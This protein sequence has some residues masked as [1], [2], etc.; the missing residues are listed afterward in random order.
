MQDS[1]DNVFNGIPAGVEEASRF[2]KFVDDNDFSPGTRRA[3]WFDLRKFSLWF[4][5]SNHEHFSLSRITVRDITD[6][7]EHLRRDRQQAVATVNRSLVLLR[8]YLQ[9]ATDQGLISANPAKPVKEIRQ[10][11]L[12]PKGLDRPQV[13]T[14]L[15]EVELRGDLRAAAIFHLLLYTG[16]RVSD[17]CNLELSDVQIGERVG[18]VTFR[19]GKGNK[20]RSVPL[21]MTARRALQMYLDVRPPVADTQLFIGERGPLTD[22]GIRALCDKYAAAA[23]L[24]LHPHL[25]RHTFAHQYLADNANDLVGL[26]QLLGHENINTTQRYS[27][28]TQDQLAGSVERVTY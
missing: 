20:H 21:P 12:A 10:Q 3:L 9:W 27:R 28:H 19:F 6:F 15:R 2:M 4:T 16:G 13:R 17:V 1:G 14:L 26:A 22:R 5:T 25:L 23:G 24:A 7:R 18:H 11:A 8:R